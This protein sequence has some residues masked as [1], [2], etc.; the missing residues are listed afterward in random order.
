MCFHC[1][2]VF[3]FSFSFL[4]FPPPPEVYLSFAIIHKVSSVPEKYRH[5]PPF[6]L[7][8]E[9]C[10]AILPLPH[11]TSV[12]TLLYRLAILFSQLKN[13]FYTCNYK[14]CGFSRI[15]LNTL[16]RGCRKLRTRVFLIIL[17]N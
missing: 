8:L 5:I 9:L 17:I 13:Y 4:F 15:Q 11:M 6:S 1:V 10:R 7:K 2:C 16:G 12:L 14:L 3:F